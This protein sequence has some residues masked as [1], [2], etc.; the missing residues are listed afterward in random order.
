M[1]CKNCKNPAYNADAPAVKK[2]DQTY[3]FLRFLNLEIQENCAKFRA[4]PKKPLVL[5][6]FQGCPFCAKVREAITIL[7]LD[8]LFKPCP[9]DG[10]TFR[11]YAISVGGKKQFPYLE[12]PNTQTEMYESDDIIRYLYETYGPLPKRTNDGITDTL[13]TGDYAE[14][15]T[16][17]TVRVNPKP[18]YAT[19]L[20]TAL[21]LALRGGKGSR[22][23]VDSNTYNFK[24]GNMQPVEFWA[25]EGSPFCRIVKEVLNEL[26]IP[27]IQRTCARGSPKRDVLLKKVGHFQVPYIED[28]NTG[29]KMFESAEIIDYLKKQYTGVLKS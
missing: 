13:I 28:P 27:H 8:V 6:E 29:V 7:D 22:Y 1:V 15:K 11:P 24:N 18:G 17:P 10:P 19:I 26:E 3:S 2:E 4:R 14:K 23:N 9:Q 5:Y 16:P 20:S 25:Y 21:G 12:D